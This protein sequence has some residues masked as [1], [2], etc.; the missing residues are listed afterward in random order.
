MSLYER[1]LESAHER[2]ALAGRDSAKFDFQMEFLAPDEDMGG[3]MW[4]Q[5]YEV[6]VTSSAGKS[7]SY[8]G[9]IGKNWVDRFGT[10]LAAGAFD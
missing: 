7:R 2:L 9:G 8:I 3:G 10:D 5:E 4:T 1:E 6:V